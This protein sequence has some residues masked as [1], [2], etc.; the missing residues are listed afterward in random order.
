MTLLLW[1]YLALLR[2]RVRDRWGRLIRGAYRVVVRLRR[3]RQRRRERKLAEIQPWSVYLPPARDDLTDPEIPKVPAEPVTIPG[4]TCPWNNGYLPPSK[5][6]HRAWCP[7][8][9]AE[10]QNQV[11]DGPV[12]AH[13]PT[14]PLPVYRPFNGTF[15]YTHDH[16]PVAFPASRNKKRKPTGYIPRHAKV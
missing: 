1:L 10:P 3:L 2:Y 11:A 7:V 9:N 4:C 13:T 15:I 8:V 16:P 6:R 14:A 12:W 5:V